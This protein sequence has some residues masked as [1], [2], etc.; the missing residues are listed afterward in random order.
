M[1]SQSGD[2]ARRLDP[3]F[4]TDGV[5]SIIN[6]N[7]PW[8]NI[9]C[10]E[11]GP[12][13]KIYVAGTV[14]GGLEPESAFVLGRFEAN[15]TLDLGFGVS[16]FAHWTY[17]NCGIDQVQSFAFQSDGKVV[18]N[19][20]V[21]S[22][23]LLFAAFSRVCVDGWVD[24]D[25]GTNGHTVLDI[26]LSPPAKRQSPKT[27]SSK[28]RNKALYAYSQ[29]GAKSR[30]NVLP[31]G[32][33][34]TAFS[35]VFN[36]SQIYGLLIRLD[37]KGFLDASFNQ[38][39]YLPVIHPDYK[40]N[41]TVLRNVLVQPDGKYLGCGNVYDDSAKPSPAMFVRY[42]SS[43]RLD[44]GF[45]TQGFV[46]MASEF[47]DNLIKATVMQPNQRILGF[48]D[49]LGNEGVMISL[50]PDGSRNI[51][52]NGGQPLYTE[53]EPDA[54]TSWTAAAIQG[55]GRIVLSGGLGV[56]GQADIVVARFIDA[57]FDTEF[58][59]RGWVCT[60]L[61]NGVQLANDMTLQEGG[62]LVCA[63]LPN[64]RSALLRYLS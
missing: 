50:E 58:H 17:D 22:A 27:P 44:E 49:T 16:G 48:G 24:L 34:L 62:I 25:Y 12:D 10:V 6:N 20:T 46:T 5:A 26:V 3:D 32:K 56:R 2:N 61:E 37:D 55:N 63:T 31:D 54:I 8:I 11:T 53:L 45:G 41:A 42:D 57:E 35:Y 28:R 15:G 30:I 40:F 52:F 14:C 23:G 18:V 13:Q 29:S 9:S 64:G 43:G 7:Y 4:G 47:H 60:R 38:I 59:D 33:T 51:Q 39:G 19:C 36:L 21:F 1:I